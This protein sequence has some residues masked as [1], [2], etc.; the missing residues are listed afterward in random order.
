MQSLCLSFSLLL[1]PAHSG[2]SDR[3]GCWGSY[4]RF[5]SECEC[6]CERLWH[7]VSEGLVGQL[8]RFRKFSAIS[9]IE[10]S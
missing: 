1:A 10:V 6:E 4:L 9:F 5:G 8:N 2:L 7:N 3:S